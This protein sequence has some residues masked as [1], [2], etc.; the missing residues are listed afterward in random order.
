MWREV[1]DRKGLGNPP[2]GCLEMRIAREVAGAV[3]SAGVLALESLGGAA[4]G[5][6]EARGRGV[7]C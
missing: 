6:G 2:A 4:L 5:G 3:W 1:E 7:V